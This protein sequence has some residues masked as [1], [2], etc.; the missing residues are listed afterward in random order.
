MPA[1]IVLA[2]IRADRAP[3][4]TAQST[5]CALRC[6][7]WPSTRSAPQPDD[8]RATTRRRA[9]ATY[10]AAVVDLLGA[11]AYGELTAF[12]RL[13]DD[14]DLAPTLPHKA[15]LA[16]LAV[17]EFR[18]FERAASRGCD[19]LGVDPEA[20]MEPFVAALDAFHERTAPERWLEG[21]VKAYVGDGIATRLLPRDLG[22]R[23]RSTPARWC[24]RVLEDT[25]HAEFVVRAVRE[26]IEADPRIAG[27][28]AL[29]GRRLVGEALSQ[30][31]RVAAERDA[32]AGAAGRWRAT[33][34]APTSPSSA[35]CSPGSPTSTPA[36]WPGSAWP[37]ER[38]SRPD[39]RTHGAPPAQGDGASLRCCCGV[40][41]SADLL[42][43]G[44]VAVDDDQHGGHD[45]AMIQRIQSMPLVSPPPSGVVRCSSR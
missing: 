9:T 43:A 24:A 36:G 13:A 31:Q 17:A 14:A 3:V 33:A 11:L 30:A 25:G 8:R 16:G 7:P 34:R 29:W 42:L 12:D 5:G 40:S 28:L 41:R 45:D 10:R 1:Q 44:D 21:L 19:E 15:A 26:A 2:A 27:R 18:H 4:V 32:L 39:R 38:G 6:G 35:G 20:A 22:L 37:P 23:R